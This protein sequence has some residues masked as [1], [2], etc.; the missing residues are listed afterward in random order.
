MSKAVETAQDWVKLMVQ[1]ESRGAGDRINAMRRLANRYGLPYST[2]WN[3]A[4][5]PPRDLYVSIYEKIEAAYA[6]ETR[7]AVTALEHERA[8]YEARTK[9]G[10][11]LVGLA[12]LLDREET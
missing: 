5:R 7:R 2:I 10:E 11:S 3:L 4:Y 1:R 9:V 6:C 12:D 8:F